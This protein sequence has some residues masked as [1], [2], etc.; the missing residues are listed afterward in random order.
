[1]Q[2]IQLLIER[3]ISPNPK[4][5]KILGLMSGLLAGIVQMIFWLDHYFIFQWLN[6]AFEGVLNDIEFTSLGIFTTSQ[7]TTKKRSLQAETE[8]A[9]TKK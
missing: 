6:T 8:E 7:L 5:F 9:L 4:L 2:F 1:M 3:F